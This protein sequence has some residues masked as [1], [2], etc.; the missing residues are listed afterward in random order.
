MR[1]KGKK[2]KQKGGGGKERDL[3]KPGFERWQEDE[4]L[5]Y[6]CQIFEWLPSRLL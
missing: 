5:M 4:N 1:E 2:E 3:H 6:E